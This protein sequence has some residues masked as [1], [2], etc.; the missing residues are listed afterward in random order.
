MNNA[1]L[2]PAQVA[3]LLAVPLRTLQYWRSQRRGPPH[4][5]LGPKLFRYRRE[6][7]EKFVAESSK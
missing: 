1:L 5:Q 3:D 4:I 7:V 6:D 2:T